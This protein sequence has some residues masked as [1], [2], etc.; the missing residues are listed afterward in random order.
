MKDDNEEDRRRRPLSAWAAIFA[1]ILSAGSLWVAH[2]SWLN[3]TLQ[4]RIQ[5]GS[6]VFPEMIE[7]QHQMLP[8]PELYEYFYAGRNASTNVTDSDRRAMVVA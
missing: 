7:I 2:Q 5:T 8:S 4:S 1:V 6:G 3:S